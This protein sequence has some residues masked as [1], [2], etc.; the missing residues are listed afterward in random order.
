MKDETYMSFVVQPFQAHMVPHYYTS[1]RGI[2]VAPL[3]SLCRG[4]TVGDGEERTLR[5]KN[6]TRLFVHSEYIKSLNSFKNIA[7]IRKV[8]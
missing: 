7:N 2:V 3:N 8:E 1:Y 4:T 6:R 5:Q